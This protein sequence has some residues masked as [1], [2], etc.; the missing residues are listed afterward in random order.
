MADKIKWWVL[1][2]SICIGIAG[3]MCLLDWTRL[4]EEITSLNKQVEQQN[5]LIDYLKQ[6]ISIKLEDK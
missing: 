1:L 2:I 3:G 5:M 6:E 4:R